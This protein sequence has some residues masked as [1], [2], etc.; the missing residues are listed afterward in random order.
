MVDEFQDTN[1]LQ[2][3]LLE[4]VA[5]DNACTVGDELQ[6]IYAFRHADVEVFRARRERLEAIGQTA[7]LATNF[8]SRPEILRALNDGFGPL[9]DRWVRRCAPAATIRRPAS[10][11]SSCW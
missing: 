1:P 10:R 4:L 9:H 6:A 11:W 5:R 2:L 8:R 7:T 3:E